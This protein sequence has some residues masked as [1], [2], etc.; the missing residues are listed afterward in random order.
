MLT[1]IWA[2]NE[3]PTHLVRLVNLA[4]LR[5]CKAIIFVKDNSLDLHLG[6]YRSE[7]RVQRDGEV[8]EGRYS[9]VWET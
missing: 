1:T 2:M 9:G 8:F 5:Y 4:R 6:A 3:S 7:S